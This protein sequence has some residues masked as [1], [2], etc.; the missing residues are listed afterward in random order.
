MR[1]RATACAD[2]LQGNMGG[3]GGFPVQGTLRLTSSAKTI[4]G[5]LRRQIKQG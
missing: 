2:V 5:A 4:R 1:R 3:G